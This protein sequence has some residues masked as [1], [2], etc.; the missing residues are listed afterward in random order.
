MGR[1]NKLKL[2]LISISAF[3]FLI[4]LLLLCIFYRKRRPDEESLKSRELKLEREFEAA[5]LIGFPGG[6]DLTVRDILDAPGEVVGKSG[7]GTLYKAS[8]Q[9]RGSVVVLR[10]LQPACAGRAE[11][12]IPAIRMMGL[13]RHANLVPLQAFYA[14]PKGEKLLVH[15]YFRCGTLWQ[16]LHGNFLRMLSFGNERISRN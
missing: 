14:G 16:F 12:V 2:I 5:D 6:E 13:I 15:P 7:Y 10:F 3:L 11:D 8:L 1:P 9:R 4:L